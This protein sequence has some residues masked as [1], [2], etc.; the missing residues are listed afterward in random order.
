MTSTTTLRAGKGAVT[1]SSRAAVDAGLAMLAAGGNAV[2]AAV[3]TALAS[4]VADCCNT[5]LGGYGGHMVIAP[6]EGPAVCVDFNAWQPGCLDDREIGAARAGNGPEASCIPNVVAGL[7]RALAAH[8][9]LRWEAVCAP[10]IRLAEEGVVMN[11]TTRHAFAEVRDQAFLKDAFRIGAAGPASVFRQPLLAATLCSL[12]EHGADWFYTGPVAEAACAAWREL[13]R[14]VTADDFAGALEAVSVSP[15]AVAQVGGSSLALAPPGTSGSVSALATMAAGAGRL[16]NGE[17]ETADGIADWAERI[18]GAW[19][20]RMGT[21][22]GNRFADGAGLDTWLAAA[23]EC[24]PA[25][26]LRP[27]NGHTCHLNAADG[28]GTLVALTLTHGPQWFGARWVLPGTGIVM[29]AGMGL[30]ADTPAQR[31]DG[32]AYAV[33][34]MAPSVARGPDGARLAVGCP[35]GRRIPTNVGMV[36]AR[37]LF[38]GMPLQQAVAAGRVH[39]ETTRRAGVESGRLPA[40][41]ADVLARRFHRVREEDWRHY[42]GPLTAIRLSPEGAVE[43]GLDDREV[44]GYGSEANP[45]TR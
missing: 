38:G 27:A 26:R 18:A 7:D 39:A 6:A 22:D 29:N 8:G 35:G 28:D 43:L 25:A 34:N 23:L 19:A 37:H 9:S 42:F 4:C 12:A 31:R 13:G 45:C 24:R 16:R 17:A 15:A 11:N 40:G 41:S 33:T 5:G 20:Y 32:R 1:G 3:A 36:L 21:R 2:D 30:F 14:E 10:A 44:N